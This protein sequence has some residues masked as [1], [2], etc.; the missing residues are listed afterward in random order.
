MVRFPLD[1]RKLLRELYWRRA[2]LVSCAAA[3]E[4]EDSVYRL[5]YEFSSPLSKTQGHQVLAINRGEREDILKAS[6]DMDRETALVA[7]RRKVV[8]GRAA[9]EFV[10]TAAE[11]AYDRLIAP[12]LE[13]EVRSELTEKASEGAIG[14]FA[15]NLKPLLMQPPVKGF[16]TIGVAVLLI[17]CYLAQ[18]NIHFVYG[19]SEMT[20]PDS[21]IVLER[22]AINDRFG[23]SSSFALLVPQGNTAKEQA[24]NDAI[25]DLP[26]VSS[27]L[28]YVETVGRS[29]PDA[30]VPPDQLKLLTSGGYT[31]LVVSARIPSESAGTF[32]FV[33]ELRAIGLDAPHTV[34]LLHGLRADGF[35]VPLDALGIQECAEAIVNALN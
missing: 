10:K 23:E 28:S 21:Q 2:S 35:D 12:S 19:A 31:R 7:L 15:L 11:D 25:K 6:V 16:V 4:P 26:Q 17:P 1:L 9:M 29:I 24:L 30:Y 13:R 32:R 5:Y 20:G 18:Q 34:E 8:P 3:K 22:N 33:E 14:Q 27:V